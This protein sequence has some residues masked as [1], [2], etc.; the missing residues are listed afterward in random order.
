MHRNRVIGGVIGVLIA[1]VAPGISAVPSGAT[2][3]TS[4]DA[5]LLAAA[6]CIDRA[7]VTSLR[8]PQKGRYLTDI[9]AHGAVDAQTAMWLQTNNWPVSYSGGPDVCWLGARISDS[10]RSKSV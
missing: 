4:A 3:A 5:S 7:D 2:L 10:F 8:G 9:P 1:L 6:R